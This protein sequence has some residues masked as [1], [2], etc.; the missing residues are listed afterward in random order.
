MCVCVCV[1]VCLREDSA[2]NFYLG[3]LCEKLGRGWEDAFSHYKHAEDLYPTAVDYVYR[4]HASRIKLLTTLKEKETKEEM[5]VGGV[6]ETM[7]GRG[8]V[9]GGGG[10][11]RVGYLNCYPHSPP[12]SPLFR[13]PCS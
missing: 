9:G 1:H 2:Y 5:Q 3:K 13:L 7:G 12:A 10:D 6:I 8:G 4:M 11:K